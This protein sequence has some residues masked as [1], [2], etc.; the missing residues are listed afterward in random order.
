MSKTLVGSMV[1][2]V[3]FSNIYVIF[4]TIDITCLIY[5][6]LYVKVRYPFNV[7]AFYALFKNFQYAFIENMYL[8]L[9]HVDYV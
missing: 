1:V 6:L 4:S 8:K 5:F 2:V 9:V 3:L 7:V